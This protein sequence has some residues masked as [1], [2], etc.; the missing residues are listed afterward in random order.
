MKLIVIL[1]ASFVTQY[2]AILT[3]TRRERTIFEATLLYVAYLE[4]PNHAT[5]ASYPLKIVSFAT[6]IKTSTDPKSY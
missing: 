4:Y 6:T 5:Y 2:E 3:A 1:L